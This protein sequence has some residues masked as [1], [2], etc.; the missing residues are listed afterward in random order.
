MKPSLHLALFLAVALG[1]QTATAKW[2]EYS[3]DTLSPNASYPGA[4]NRTFEVAGKTCTIRVVSKGCGG[5]ARPR[6]RDPMEVPMWIHRLSPSLTCCV[7]SP[8]SPSPSAIHGFWIS[9]H[10]TPPSSFRPI[11]TRP[12]ISCDNLQL[13]N[14]THP[15]PRIDS[16]VCSGLLGHVNVG[17]VLGSYGYNGRTYCS[18]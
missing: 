14:E 9:V 11:S 13:D 6:T 8:P 15:D 1:T 17:E 2:Q 4:G 7:S 12:V 18:K 5:F 16:Y 10:Q 3:G